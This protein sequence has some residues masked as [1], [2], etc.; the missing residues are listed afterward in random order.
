MATDKLHKHRA[1][2]RSVA[3]CGLKHIFL[4]YITPG[5]NDIIKGIK[6]FVS[7]NLL[8]EREGVCKC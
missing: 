3:I 1:Y 7:E 8:S 4:I 6:D 2:E 5:E